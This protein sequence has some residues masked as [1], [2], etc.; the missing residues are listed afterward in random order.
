MFFNGY[1]MN[2]FIYYG[3]IYA[4]INRHTKMIYIGGTKN[5]NN[6]LRNHEFM[7]RGKSHICKRFQE[8]FN[9]KNEFMGLILEKIRGEYLNSK[10][11][12]WT[13]KYLESR[14]QEWID[15]YSNHLNRKL[16]NF[17]CKTDFELEN[18]KKIATELVEK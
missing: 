1:D 9:N 16:Y 2:E 6:R 18:S 14:E 17:N 11:E 4:L 13:R 8:D 5:L 3:G 10:P 12:M 7:L 15:F